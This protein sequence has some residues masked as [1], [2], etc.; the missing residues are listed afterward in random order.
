MQQELD[1]DKPMEKDLG[2]WL[3]TIREHFKE[4]PKRA[5]CAAI[6]II[7]LLHPRGKDNEL[8]RM[9]LR[10]VTESDAEISVHSIGFLIREIGWAQ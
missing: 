10:T 9:R 5:L 1:A 2:S 3:T 8:M 4:R 7:N 6:E